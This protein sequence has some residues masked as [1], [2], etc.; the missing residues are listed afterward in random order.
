[1]SLIIKHE[2]QE[3]DPQIIRCGFV[4]AIHLRLCDGSGSSSDLY[5]PHMEIKNTLK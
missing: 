3:P 5:V 4:V 1:M 2:Q